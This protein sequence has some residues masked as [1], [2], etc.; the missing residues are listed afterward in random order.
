M[1]QTFSRLDSENNYLNILNEEDLQ[2][3]EENLDISP[4]T[5]NQVILGD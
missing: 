4:V 5:K 2:L 3:G 1:R